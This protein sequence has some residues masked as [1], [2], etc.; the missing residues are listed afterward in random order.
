MTKILWT[1]P[2]PS[3]SLTEGGATLSSLGGRELSLRTPWDYEDGPGE[4]TL[5][6]T[7]VEAYRCTFMTACV[8][9]MND[10]YDRLIDCGATDWLN[11]VRAANSRHGR[12][13]EELRHLMFYLD[14]GPCYEFIC[15]S[16]RN[17]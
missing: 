11:E 15:R 3:T 12:S 8:P 9:A 1:L 2:V 6:F 5:F 4:A 14:D 17:Q 7:G 16:F 10:A 13:P